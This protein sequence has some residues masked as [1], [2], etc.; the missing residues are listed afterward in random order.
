MLFPLVLL[1][2]LLLLFFTCILLLFFYF[3]FSPFT[4]MHTHSLQ[5]RSE[6]K[7]KIKSNTHIHLNTQIYNSKNATLTHTLT[8]ICRYLKINSC[9][10]MFCSLPS[11]RAKTKRNTYKRPQR[12]TA[13]KGMRYEYQLSESFLTLYSVFVFTS[14]ALSC[15][16]LLF[17]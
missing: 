15:F 11:Q 13:S 1:L 16:L 12:A 3:F 2:L 14:C 7:M 4:H 10:L 17:Y 9:C 8:I 5:S 6:K